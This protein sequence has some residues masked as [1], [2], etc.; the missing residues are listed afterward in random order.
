LAFGCGVEAPSVKAESNPEGIAII[1]PSNGVAR[2]SA[3]PWVNPTPVPPTLKELDH[4]T[5]NDLSTPQE[6]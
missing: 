1:Q 6:F 2:H 3:L 5:S 4:Q